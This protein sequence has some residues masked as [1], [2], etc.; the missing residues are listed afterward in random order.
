MLSGSGDRKNGMDAP[1]TSICEIGRRVESIS[2]GMPGA[3]A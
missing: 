3:L 2:D 1:R